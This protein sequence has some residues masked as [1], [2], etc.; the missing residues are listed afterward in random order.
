MLR[1]PVCDIQMREMR[2]NDVI[3][4]R[5]DFTGIEEV[6][7]TGTSLIVRKMSN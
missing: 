5:L 4:L 7:F 6:A 3:T 2:A 1:F